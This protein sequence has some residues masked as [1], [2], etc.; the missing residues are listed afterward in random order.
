MLCYIADAESKQISIKPFQVWLNKL[1]AV[2]HVAD[3]L[4]EDLQYEVLIKTK[5]GGSKGT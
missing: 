3:V 4:M 2:A 1:K 5:G